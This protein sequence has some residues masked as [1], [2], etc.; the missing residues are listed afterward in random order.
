MNFII[1]TLALLKFGAVLTAAIVQK[2]EAEARLAHATIP[3]RRGR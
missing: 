3:A 1:V 2:R